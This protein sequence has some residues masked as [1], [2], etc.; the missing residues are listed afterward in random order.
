MQ[1]AE[2][3]QFRGSLH[4][5]NE[6]SANCH[7]RYH[8]QRVNADLQHLAYRC[9]PTITIPDKRQRLHHRTQRRPKLN[10]QTPNIVELSEG[11]SS[12]AFENICHQ[13]TFDPEEALLQPFASNRAS[14][15]VTSNK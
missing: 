11:L 10:I 1:G 2:T 6:P 14:T 8:R 15:P 4:G 5:E 9:L 12:D 3:A 7:Q 13:D